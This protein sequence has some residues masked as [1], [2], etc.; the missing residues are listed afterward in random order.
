MIANSYL[1]R[2]PTTDTP[3]GST[4]AIASPQCTPGWTVTVCVEGEYE[5][6]VMC[7]NEIE[8]PWVMLPARVNSVF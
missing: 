2:P 4:A 1:A 3:K 8:T 7:E 6:L 5:T